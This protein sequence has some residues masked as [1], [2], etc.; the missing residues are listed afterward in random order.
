M[1]KKRMRQKRKTFREKIAL[2]W[3]GRKKDDVEKLQ[4]RLNRDLLE[5]AEEGRISRV[6]RLLSMGASINA[7]DENGKSPLALAS[8]NGHNKTTRILLEAVEKKE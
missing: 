7:R 6:R 4:K 8:H 3:N 2:L 5:A 1:V